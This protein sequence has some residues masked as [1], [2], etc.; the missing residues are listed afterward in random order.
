MHVRTR[1]TMLKDIK[2]APV[3]VRT[4]VR[5]APLV[6]TLI[7]RVPVLNK[8]VCLCMCC[9]DCFFCFSL[10]N[11]FFFLSPPGPPLLPFSFLLF[12]LSNKEQSQLNKGS[13]IRTGTG[14]S[15]G[16][17]NGHAIEELKKKK[18]DSD[19]QKIFEEE[20]AKMRDDLSEAVHRLRKKETLRVS[21]LKALIKS[22]GEEPRGTWYY[23]YHQWNL[24]REKA[25]WARTEFFTD[26]DTNALKR[27][28]DDDFSD[29]RSRKKQNGML[30]YVLF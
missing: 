19:T 10:S 3:L 7:V 11:N 21:D 22:K 14:R 18:D 16:T 9:Y 2:T 1:H 13:D 6:L 8:M 17:R 23:L 5:L 12:R 4:P 15:A 30:V 24:V 27:L 25:D 28:E 26:D 20:L 29:T